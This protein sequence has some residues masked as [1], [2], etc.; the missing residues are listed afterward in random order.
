VPLTFAHPVAVLPLRRWFLFVALASGA[1]APDYLYFLPLPKTFNFKYGHVF[2][3]VIL[4]SVP[5]AIFVWWLWRWMVRDG[6]IA[7]LPTSEQQ[8]FMADIPAFD[9][10]STKDWAM[11]FVAVAIG[12]ASHLL[13]DSFSHRDGW[14][15]EHIGF[16]TSTHVHLINRDLAAYKL[17]QYFGSLVGMGVLV[18]AYLGWSWRAPRNRAFR[19]LWSPVVRGI[20]VAVVVILS[21]GDAYRVALHHRLEESAETLAAAIIAGAQ[22]IFVALLVIAV[23][24]RVQSRNVAVD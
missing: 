10:R 9:R 1:M 18:L 21:A 23:V 5:A 12:I 7:M 2:P 22:V 20:V 15:T 8:K 19:P 16:L 11:L 24:V 13:L 4:F 17:V 6:V 14:G 3:G